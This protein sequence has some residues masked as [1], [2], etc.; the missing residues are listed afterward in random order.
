[1]KKNYPVTGV[2]HEFPNG[3]VIISTT[4]L[5]GAITNFNEDFL[6]ISGFEAGELLGKNHNIVRHPDMPPPAFADLWQTLKAGKPWMGVV[7]NRCKNGDHYWVNAYVTPMFDD[8]HIVGYESVRVKP[9]RELVERAER[10]YKKI[11]AGKRPISRWR[12]L[13]LTTKIAAFFS[14][15]TALTLT[16]LAAYGGMS[17]NMAGVGMLI[18]LLL[19]IGGAYFFG[20]CIR[21]ASRGVEDI[22][23]NPVMQMVY[24]GRTNE[25][26]HLELATLMLRARLRTVLNRTEHSAT[27][28]AVAAAQTAAVMDSTSESVE[29]QQLETTQVATAMNEMNAT[30]NEVAQ[31]TSQA[32]QAAQEADSET[33]NGRKVVNDT[34]SDIQRLA[35]EVERAASVIQ[36][37]KA[38][39]EN[40]GSV[41][42]V[43][44]GIAEQTNLL[45]L[46]AAIEAA[47]AG[48]QGRG[49]AVVADEVR[50]LASRTQESTEEIRTMVD[51]LQSGTEEA[52]KVMLSGRERAQHT[53]EQAAQ[54]G[55]SLDS[56]TR[57]VQVISD[58]NLQIASAAEQQNAVVE[59]INR[60]I[61]N[62][63]DIGSQ[64]SS[65]V[66]ETRQAAH[67]LVELAQK[68]KAM[69]HQ[70]NL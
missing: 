48:E 37:L 1:M 22:V 15:V 4:D 64:T 33:Q 39:S 32:A 8:G 14:G 63:N 41:V 47:R 59:E 25:V 61:T 9:S 57:A 21:A 69:V 60:N 38:K 31:N 68:L 62:I 19:N 29:R 51:E 10:I 58:M 11:W 17:W 24:C 65:A 26:S 35:D 7:K 36:T 12:G 23:S 66:G 70:F 46:N 28:L 42:A 49:F 45:A 44:N 56:I 34:A 20:T 50:N 54:A 43:I 27:Q 6:A 53:V 2:E 52:V 13:S 40:I 5:K 3:A 67:Q 30:V 18:G 16:A 55:A